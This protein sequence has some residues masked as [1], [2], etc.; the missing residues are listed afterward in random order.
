V[1]LGGRTK[2][3]GHNNGIGYGLD[4]GLRS[5]SLIDLI[6]KLS[7]SKHS[8]NLT[9]SSILVSADVRLGEIADFGFTLG[10]GPGFYFFDTGALTETDF[11]IHAGV[12]ADLWMEEV[13]R[14][15]LEFRW[16]SLFSGTVG[17]NYWTLMMRL[18]YVFEF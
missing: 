5:N 4:L 13:I 8:N 17:D 9:L 1:G 15:G 12:G 10:V 11:G 3:A 2:A 14:I 7:R 6:F 18:G 16:N